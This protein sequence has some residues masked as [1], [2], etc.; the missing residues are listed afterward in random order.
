M[1]QK[2]TPLNLPSGNNLLWNCPRCREQIC[3]SQNRKWNWQILTCMLNFGHFPGGH[4]CFTC[5]FVAN[6]KVILLKSEISCDADPKSVKSTLKF[7][8]FRFCPLNFLVLRVNR[9][10]R[11]QIRCG[12]LKW[13]T[14]VVK[15]LAP[16]TGT[17]FEDLLDT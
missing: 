3:K 16:S 9:V 5:I 4:F 10:F 12:L 11:K 13:I 7:L 8:E 1:L 2:S 17:D 14:V 6:F 15:L